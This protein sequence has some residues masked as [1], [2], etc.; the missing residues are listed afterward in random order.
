[1]NNAQKNL[2]KRIAFAI[3]LMI[4]IWIVS[5]TL[6]KS[7]SDEWLSMHRNTLLLS[8]FVLLVIGSA[9]G[10]KNEPM[11][12]YSERHEE[13]NRLFDENP[14][15][16]VYVVI[17]SVALAIGLYYVSSNHVDMGALLDKVGFFGFAAAILLLMLP[18]FIVKLKKS[19]DDAGK[20]K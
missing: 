15:T 1:M 3:V 14:W 16:K 13:F 11:P 18:I 4:L 2:V 20:E 12:T 9:F 7:L 6:S 19:Y 10:K 8:T 5:S 17:Y